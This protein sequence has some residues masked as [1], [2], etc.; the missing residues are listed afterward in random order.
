MYTTFNLDSRTH[1]K[2]I[3]A[4]VSYRAF[5]TVNVVNFFCRA[6]FSS[7]TGNLANRSPRKN[8][9][10]LEIIATFYSA[11]N[12]AEVQATDISLLF[13]LCVCRAVARDSGK[14][15]FRDAAGKSWDSATEFDRFSIEVGSACRA[16]DSKLGRMIYAVDSLAL[17]PTEI[18]D[19]GTRR[20]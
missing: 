7:E 2:K 8:P 19:I 12:L 9:F 1:K 3:F 20:T 17:D 16:R 5:D 15:R 6:S 14:T 18:A 10:S 13:F 11:C 4:S